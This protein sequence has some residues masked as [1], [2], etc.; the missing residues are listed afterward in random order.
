MLS[1][2]VGAKQVAQVE[3]VGIRS[4]IKKGKAC[5]R[6]GTESM[7]EYDIGVLEKVLYGEKE[8]YEL[9]SLG[10]SSKSV[11]AYRALT[12]LGT[13][14]SGDVARLVSSVTPYAYDTLNRLVEYG[15]VK[16]S[17]LKPEDRINCSPH[18]YFTAVGLAGMMGNV[19]N[20]LKLVKSREIKEGGLSPQAYRKKKTEETKEELRRLI[21]SR[22]RV[23]EEEY[24][25]TV[26]NQY[27]IY[28]VINKAVK[29]SRADGV[30]LYLA[31]DIK[32]RLKGLGAKIFWT[33]IDK[34]VMGTKIFKSERRKSRNIVYVG[35][36]DLIIVRL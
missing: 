35:Q 1:E 14:S 16:K 10:L 23:D 27:L 13:A 25:K 33:D 9:L 3:R 29:G 18:I 32:P 31:W 21:G 26:R 34:E 22:I 30:S 4:K 28:S 2:Q 7:T 8:I 11:I 12:E 6:T 24:K 5:S 17:K 19:K 36:K 20:R 15:L